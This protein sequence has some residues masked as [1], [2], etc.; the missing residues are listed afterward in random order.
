[1]FPQYVDKQKKTMRLARSVV[2]PAPTNSMHSQKHRKKLTSMFVWWKRD[3]ICNWKKTFAAILTKN[4]VIAM[5]HSSK[6]EEVG[7][8]MVNRYMNKLEQV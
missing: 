8:C 1:M 4:K 6:L 7:V 5:C 2:A 3:A